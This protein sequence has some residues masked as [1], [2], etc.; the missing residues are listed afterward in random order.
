MV[1]FVLAQQLFIGQR[2]APMC[3]VTGEGKNS[4]PANAGLGRATV[5]I[6]RT[7]PRQ[8][9]FVTVE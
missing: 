6:A 1:T 9:D 2:M 4:A 3:G 8:N 5:S 7:A